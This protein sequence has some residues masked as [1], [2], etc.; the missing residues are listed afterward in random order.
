MRV[1]N[2]TKEENVLSYVW[3]S[4]VSSILSK[5]FVCFFLWGRSCLPLIVYN[6]PT[7]CACP[8]AQSCPT[9]C[10]PM[11]CIVCQ[12]PLSMEF[13][14]QEYWSGLPF[15]SPG[16]LPDPGIKLVSP[17]SPAL[18]RGFFTTS[19]TWEATYPQK[20]TGNQKGSKIMLP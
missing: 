11:D 2:F 5:T 20:E 12:A 14:R 3:G 4:L 9:L 16:N 1:N 13:S 19:A 17:E 8:V 6:N 10:D 18:A 15:P 7:K